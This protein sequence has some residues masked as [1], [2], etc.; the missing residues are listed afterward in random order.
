[1]SLVKNVLTLIHTIPEA[2]ISEDEEVCINIWIA[3][4]LSACLQCLEVLSIYPRL[5][6]GVPS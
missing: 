4:T 3:C 6:V 1:M 5:V 2:M